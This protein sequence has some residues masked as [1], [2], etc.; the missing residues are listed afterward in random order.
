[1]CRKQSCICCRKADA[2][3]PCCSTRTA[4][5]PAAAKAPLPEQ[6]EGAAGTSSCM[7]CRNSWRVKGS[8]HT[9]TYAAQSLHMAGAKGRCLNS[10]GDQGEQARCCGGGIASSATGLIQP[11]HTCCFQY[12]RCSTCTNLVRRIGSRTGFERRAFHCAAEEP[13]LDDSDA[14]DTQ[15][16]LNEAEA[17][18]NPE[19]DTSD[20]DW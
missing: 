13:E 18:M 7:L 17:D 14:F 15:D 19:L 3:W 8:R 12:T 1:M 11:A 6:V 2:A 5:K 10:T 16:L 4:A 9:S 20:T